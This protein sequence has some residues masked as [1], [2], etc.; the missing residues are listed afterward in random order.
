MC[1]FVS[2]IEKDQTIVFLTGEDV[3]KTKKGKEL[4]KHTCSED[5][6]GH[7]AIRWYYEFEG[8]R[9]RECTDFSKPENY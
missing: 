9:E 1:D 5:W 3:F 2:W 4:Q 8:G 7:G 6:I